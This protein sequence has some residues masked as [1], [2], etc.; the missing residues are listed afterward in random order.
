MDPRLSV[1]WQDENLI[2]TQLVRVFGDLSRTHGK[3]DP[4]LS[5]I[6]PTSDFIAYRATLQ[7]LPYQIVQ[8]LTRLA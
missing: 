7:R 6:T 5:I 3:N 8:W 2:I 4:T 1:R